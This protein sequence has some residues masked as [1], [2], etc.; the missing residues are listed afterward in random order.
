MRTFLATVLAVAAAAP[1]VVTGP[2]V[3][4]GQSTATLQGTVDPEGE[5]T[6]YHFE[7]GTTTSYGLTTPTQ[8]AGDGDAPVDVSAALTGLTANTTY[9]YRLVAT[10]ASGTVEGADRTFTTAANPRPPGI[11]SQRARDIAPDGARLTASLDPNGTPTTYHFEYGT[12]TRYGS[13]TPA[14]SAGAGNSVVPV[15]VNVSGLSPFTRYH[16]RLV[17]TNAAGTTRGNDR[18]FTTA[19]LPTGVTLT[20]SPA[21]VT[22]GRDL[23]LG[24]RVSGT[25]AGRMPIALQA[26]AFPFDRDFQEIART[27]TGNDGGYIFRVANLWTTTRYR[28]VTRTRVVAMS[29]VAQASS[30]VLAG[31]RVRHTSRRRARVEGSAFPGVSGTARL[32]R[33]SLRSGRWFTVRRRELSP[34]DSVRT[35]YTFGVRRERRTRSYR[36]RFSPSDG[37]AHVTGT[38]RTVRVKPRRRR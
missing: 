37:G 1:I 36:V 12:S 16:Y 20:L 25:G 7:Y 13:S 29:P 10:N 22:W 34:T 3:Q 26:Q 8:A 9:H 33:R 2:A 19:R 38:S 30:A 21:R 11:S 18:T 23:A 6:T 5:A 15:S 17:A 28:V 27:S 31:A 32:Q 35:R 14:Q 24:G 4:V